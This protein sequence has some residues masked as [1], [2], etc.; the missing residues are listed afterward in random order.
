MVHCA[1]IER[2]FLTIGQL[3]VARDHRFESALLNDIFLRNWRYALIGNKRKRWPRPLIS[4]IIHIPCAVYSCSLEAVER[5]SE[6]ATQAYILYGQKGLV[7]LEFRAT[8]SFAR[9]F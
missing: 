2:F 1:I 3:I 4:A 8:K 6:G 5:R 9:T 7:A